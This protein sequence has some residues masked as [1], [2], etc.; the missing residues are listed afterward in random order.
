MRP[1]LR[2]VALGLTVAAV[3]AFASTHRVML[4]GGD[5]MAPALEAGDV[6][7]VRRGAQVRT[8]DVLLFRRTGY[9]HVLHR[10]V[11]LHVDGTVA[12]RGDANPTGDREPVPRGDVEGRVVGALRLAR[13][14]RSTAASARWCRSACARLLPQSH[15]ERR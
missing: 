14:G 11:A 2:R 1:G 5:S 3:A 8:G 15:S 10:A 6:A 9:G 4:V 12:T 7:V 13:A